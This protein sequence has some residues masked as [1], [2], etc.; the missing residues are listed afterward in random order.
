M[1]FM[2]FSSMS[3][4]LMQVYP[5]FQAMHFF[6]IILTAISIPL[7]YELLLYLELVLLYLAFSYLSTKLI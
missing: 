6:L 2:E 5:S 7:L 1:L 3:L 4:Q